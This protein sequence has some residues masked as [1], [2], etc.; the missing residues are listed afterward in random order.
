LQ[1]AI[2]DFAAD[3]PFAQARM[4]LKEHYGVEIGQSTIQ[5]IS[6]AHAEAI[7][8][9]GRK[10]VDFPQEP[11]S[12]KPIV[13][14]T[15]GGMVPVVEPSRDGKDKRK[16]KKLSWREAKLSLAHE[17]G[18]RTPV[19]A[20]SIEGGVEAAG[21][22]LLTCAVRAGFG[23]N[24]RVHAVGDGA[25]WIVGQV[26]EQF[27]D[28]GRYLIDFYHVCEYLSA[29][30][31]AIA[32]DAA[33]RE[34]WIETQKEAIKSGRLDTTLQAL[35][36]QCEAPEVCDEQAPV[37]R[38]HRYLSS[39]TAQLDYR[40]ALANGLP[41]GSGEIESAHRYVAQ[42][43]LKLPGAWWRVEHAEHMLAL[44]INRLNGD[45]EDYW[46]ARAANLPPPANRNRPNVS[47][48]RAA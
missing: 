40:G 14:E 28:Q 12:S 45:W 18:S 22:Q 1:R 3:Q 31:A 17:K 32:S 34:S 8:E 16:G 20:G 4:K 10:G 42:K 2:V 6:F 39:R 33:A 13:V 35:A 19:Y 37:R 25:P 21:R 15:D 47:Q 5:R 48:N 23:T 11:G 43:R 7:F 9:E 38:C 36:S 46:A 24:S 41:I 44:R 26:E 27:G 30:A 29:A